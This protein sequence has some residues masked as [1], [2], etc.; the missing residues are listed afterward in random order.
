LD[1]YAVRDENFLLVA[2]AHSGAAHG[3]AARERSGAWGPNAATK[4][5]FGAEPRLDRYAVGDENFVF[6]VRIAA[7]RTCAAAKERSGA[8]GPRAA[9]KPGFGAEPRLDRYAV[10]NENFP[11]RCGSA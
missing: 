5:G 11:P 10:R 1:R 8:S 9:T 6:V 3:A 2:G 7:P 4:P